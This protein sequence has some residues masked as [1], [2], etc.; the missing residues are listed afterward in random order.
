MRGLRSKIPSKNLVHIYI[1]T[2]LKF[3]ALLGDPYTNI[4]DIS[5]LR[6][7]RSFI[8]NSILVTSYSEYTGGATVL[9]VSLSAFFETRQVPQ[10]FLRVASA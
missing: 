8:R 9:S 6:V 4:Y 7:K 5:R 3:L 1:Y 2:T 10:A